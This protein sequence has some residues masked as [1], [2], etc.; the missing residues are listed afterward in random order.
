MPE[1][2]TR[3]AFHKVTGHVGA[4]VEAPDLDLCRPLSPEVV[5]ALRQGVL[6]HGVIFFRGQEFT[7]RELEACARYFG[8]PIPEP[9]VSERMPDAPPATTGD[10]MRTRYSTNVWH[11]DTS[12][13][14]KPV[15]FTFLRAVE[16]PP[17]GGD[18]CWSCMYTAYDL[19]SEPVRKMLD[20]LTA[21]HSSAP[22]YRRMGSAIAQEHAAN[23]KIHA[24][25]REH[26]LV[27]VHPETGR[28]ALFYN[29]GWVTQIVGVTPA[30]SEHIIAL[31]RE[32]CKSPDFAMRWRWTP[33]DVA[34]WDNRSTQH[35][36][37]PDYNTTR[38]MQR[39][40]TEGEVPTPVR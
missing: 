14:E 40:V 36:A 19:L 2:L 22:V 38:I 24:R 39:V 26:P 33:N 23:D 8:K 32:H 10:L 28:K 31:L 20:R 15:M 30:E 13:L 3:I 12:F 16:L 27:I 1:T 9:F 25:E 7:D 29:E 11:H 35:Y 6:D 18:T 5:A 34:L 37:V 4:V 21:I 17:Y